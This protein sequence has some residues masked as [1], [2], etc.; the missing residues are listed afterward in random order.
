MENRIIKEVAVGIWVPSSMIFASK[1]QLKPKGQCGPLL[2]FDSQRQRRLNLA[3]G[4]P[5]VIYKSL[6]NDSL[7]IKLAQMP[8]CFCLKV[9]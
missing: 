7:D 2:I 8:L 5:D 9:K 6:V 1:L 3:S 4:T